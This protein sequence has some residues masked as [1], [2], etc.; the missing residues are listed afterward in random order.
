MTGSRVD[1]L[2][3]WAFIAAH[4]GNNP[5]RD[6]LIA[7]TIMAVHS[8]VPVVGS[9]TA[10][11]RI[12]RRPW[13]L[14]KLV[15]GRVLGPEDDLSARNPTFSKPCASPRL[16]IFIPRLGCAAKDRLTCPTGF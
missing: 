9:T 10:M 8:I 7:S 14:I 13:W 11:K 15:P 5:F 4:R 16:T 3:F 12:R 2:G 1:L 6:N